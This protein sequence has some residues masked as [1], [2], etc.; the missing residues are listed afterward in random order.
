MV[1]ALIVAV[2]AAFIGLVFGGTFE[3]LV[4]TK[5]RWLW[6]VYVGFALQLIALMW[7]PEWLSGEAE[8]AVLALTNVPIA[9]FM[10]LNY[11]LPGMVLA[12]VGLALNLLV[13]SANGAMPVA[14]GAATGIN[15]ALEES[16]VKHEWLNES[17]ELP[18]LAD[19]IPVRPIGSVLSLG[20]VLLAA[21]IG[22][23]VWAQMTRSRTK[24]RHSMSKAQH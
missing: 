1:T 11:R 3:S 16:G 14:T 12:A 8:I 2:L 17:T 24:G 22:Y 4:A 6:L 21:G 23:F 13:I 20:D 15:P 5:V 19:V 9:L 10:A 7:S 18:W